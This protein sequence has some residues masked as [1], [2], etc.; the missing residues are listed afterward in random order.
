M[1]GQ[2]IDTQLNRGISVIDEH[3]AADPYR[4]L[5]CSRF[6]ATDG[7][8]CFRSPQYSKLCASGLQNQVDT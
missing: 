8:R 7:Y 1:R 2:V 4:S 3:P 5:A 6:E